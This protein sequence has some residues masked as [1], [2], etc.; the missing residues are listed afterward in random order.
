M[1][2]SLQKLLVCVCVCEYSSLCENEI[3]GFGVKGDREKIR[4]G[5]W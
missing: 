5:E 3:N 4:G 1:R 2:I